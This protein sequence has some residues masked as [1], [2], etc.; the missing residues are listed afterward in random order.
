MNIFDDETKP[1][2]LTKNDWKNIIKC[3]YRVVLI[4]K[5]EDDLLNSERWKSLRPIDSYELKGIQIR[6]K[7]IWFKL[8]S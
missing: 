3:N 6:E 1:L 5:T 4:D 2:V 7:D 8:Y